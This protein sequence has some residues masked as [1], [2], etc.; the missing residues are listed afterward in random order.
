VAA[1][2][3]AGLPVPLASVVGLEVGSVVEIGYQPGPPYVQ[4]RVAKVTQIAGNSV[5]FGAAGLTF[6]VNQGTLVKTREFKLT[7]QWVKNGQVVESEVF[8][9]L[10]LDDRHSRYAPAILGDVNGPVRPSDRRPQGQSLYVRLSDQAT[11]AISESSIRLGPDLLAETLANGQVRA[12]GRPLTGGADPL[13]GIATSTYI[14]VD[15]DDPANRKGLYTLKNEDTISI[16]TIPGRTDQDVQAALINHCEL[17]RYRFAV[18][19]SVPGDDPIQG[20]TLT[21]VQLQR[22]Q[23]D[24]K[25]AALYYPW[26]TIADPFPLNP[27]NVLDFAVPP[28]GHMMGI[29]AA[30]DANP[31]VY[32]APANVVIGGIRGLQRRLNKAEQEILNPLPVNINVL[33]DFRAQGRGLRVWGAR[34]ITS[35]PDWIYINVRRLF[36]FLEASL[37]QGTQWVVFEPNAEPLWARVT[38]SITNFLTRVWRDGALMGTKPE[39]AFFVRCDRTTMTQDDIDEGRLIIIVGV[40]PVKPAE[41]VIIR[42]GQMAG[43]ATVEEQ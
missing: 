40:A 43:G 15:D 14:G 13:A 24:T 23:F 10:T 17:M 19:D 36:I 3:G 9:Q 21:D 7:V 8:R 18:L 31:G 32:K 29:Y 2:T 33:R 34:C 1:N 30:T 4:G 16:V 11:P 25:Y 26:V 37:D 35:D 41:F 12:A 22:S 5:T 27:Q 6:A 38:R 42:I 39:E 28:S 20:A